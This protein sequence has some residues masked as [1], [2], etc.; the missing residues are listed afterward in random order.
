MTQTIDPMQSDQ[1][2][3]T[4]ERTFV[5]AQDWGMVS[6]AE[7]EWRYRD[8]E[9]LLIYNPATE[10]LQFINTL[11]DETLSW[12]DGELIGNVQLTTDQWAEF[13][14]LSEWLDSQE[15]PQ[16]VEISTVRSPTSE[17]IAALESTATQ[18]FEYY[19]SQ[20]ISAYKL[21]EDSTIHY[22][23]VEVSGMTYL[24]SRDDTTGDYNL[25]REGSD[26]DLR[27][28]QGITQRDLQAWLEIGEWLSDFVEMKPDYPSEWEV[29]DR[30]KQ[31]NSVIEP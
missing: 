19:A 22:Y 26:L 15:V 2:R 7:R 5:L 14:E 24:L 20:E 4:L 25:Q 3:T 17:E 9:H 1:L 11:T 18:L 6:A 30:E 12:Q 21:S 29:F 23:S 16:S 10:G 31:P 13:Q 27:S 8:Q 28:K